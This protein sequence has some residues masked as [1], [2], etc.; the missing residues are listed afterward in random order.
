LRYLHYDAAK[1]TAEK[2]CPR[3][4]AIAQINVSAA[5]TD[6]LMAASAAEA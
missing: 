2:S 6:V 1:S 4:D 5:M 3:A